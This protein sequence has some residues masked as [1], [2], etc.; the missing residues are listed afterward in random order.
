MTV[1]DLTAAAFVGCLLVLRAGDKGK[2]SG[3]AN[4]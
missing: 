3:L 4:D 1:F 2:L